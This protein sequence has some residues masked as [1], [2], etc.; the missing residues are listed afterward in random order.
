MLDADLPTVK[1]ISDAVHG[2]YTEDETVYAERLKL[3]PAG[4]RIFERHGEPLGYCIAHPWRRKA[5]PSL[6]RPLGV[7]P[8]DAEAYH[9]HDIALL[10]AARGTGAGKAAIAEVIERA[11]AGGFGTIRLVAVN[12]ATD[13]WTS[14]GFIR[15]PDLAH[16]YGAEAC[17]MQR[18]L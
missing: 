7:I 10:P 18:C 14:Q 17:V 16:G 12:D 5:P 3:H 15:L 4:C 13:F 11:M 6:N 1:A 9:L 2:A 8:V